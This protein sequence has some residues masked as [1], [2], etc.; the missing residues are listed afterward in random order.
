MWNIE[1]WYFWTFNKLK[2]KPR[3]YLPLPTINTDFS[4]WKD[5]IMF[6]QWNLNWKKIKKGWSDYI[7]FPNTDYLAELKLEWWY[8][9]QI[10]FDPSAIKEFYLV[11]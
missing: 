6:I 11:D 8:T 3:Y 2:Y 1:L 9:Y 7:T 5:A 10:D 4:I